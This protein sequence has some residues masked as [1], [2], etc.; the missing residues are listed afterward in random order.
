MSSYL[1]ATQVYIP[2][3]AVQSLISGSASHES[4]CTERGYK[5]TVRVCALT[6]VQEIPAT[7]NWW[8]QTNYS[9]MRS[10]LVSDLHIPT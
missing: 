5:V 6:C 9:G 3:R 2:P 4:L 1:H 7:K 10:A 8:R